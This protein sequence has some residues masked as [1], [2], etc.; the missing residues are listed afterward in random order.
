MTNDGGA[1]VISSV[2]TSELFTDVRF[3]G[4]VNIAPQF[5]TFMGLAFVLADV[6]ADR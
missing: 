2:E 1:G 4:L 6:V 3:S 5:G